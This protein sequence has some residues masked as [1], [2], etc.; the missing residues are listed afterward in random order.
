[1]P[2]P[3]K[4]MLDQLASMMKSSGR[5]K[6]AIIQETTF[7][8]P[9]GYSIEQRRAI[10]RNPEHFQKLDM[11]PERRI[12]QRGIEARL[13]PK[14]VAADE[15]LDATRDNR[16]TIQG[17]WDDAIADAKESLRDDWESGL[18]HQAFE[19]VDPYALEV[20]T[21]ATDLREYWP[22]YAR[23]PEEISE[24]FESAQ[25]AYYDAKDAQRR[26]YSNRGIMDEQMMTPRYRNYQRAMLERV[27]N[28]RR[29]RLN[30]K[31]MHLARMGYSLPEIRA[32]LNGT[33]PTP[34]VGGR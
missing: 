2:T 31:I 25:D 9:L 8:D 26:I 14:K 3:N 15:L 19:D 20:E 11:T 30:A 21:P 13:Y 24:A 4:T 34:A 1:M 17:E 33:M 28:A 12:Y 29:G 5:K 16:E 7:R 18:D 23:S 27:E 10:A 22:G 6:P 32:M